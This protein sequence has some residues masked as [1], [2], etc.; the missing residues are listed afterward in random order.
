MIGAV[1]DGP[2]DEIVQLEY[3]EE[4]RPGRDRCMAQKEPGP[5]GTVRR[6]E[7]FGDAETQPRKKK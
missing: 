1:I 5:P 3:I 4:L 6:A 2:P 7:R